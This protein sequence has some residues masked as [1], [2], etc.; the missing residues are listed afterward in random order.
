[1]LD[2]VT[3]E[4]RYVNAGHEPPYLCRKG[5]EYEAYKIRAG[6]V[7]AGMEDLRYK[8]GSLQLATGDRIFLYTDGVTEATDADNQ[9]YG[10]ERLHRVLNDNLGANPEALLTAVKA[11]VDRFVGDAPQFDDITM[12][13]MEYR[14]Q[15]QG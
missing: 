4:F 8:E 10:S 1:M 11:D 9:L 15:T 6:F 5:E 13:C 7:L 3:G 12:L 14:G 2:L